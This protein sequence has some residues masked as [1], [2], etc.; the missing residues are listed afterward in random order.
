MGRNERGM[1]GHSANECRVCVHS[2]QQTAGRHTRESHDLACRNTSRTRR[3]RW[4]RTVAS[5]AISSRHLRRHTL[6]LPS[7][8]PSLFSDDLSHPA[9]CRQDSHLRSS[10]LA[11]RL[12]RS[13][14]A[15][16]ASR[17]LGNIL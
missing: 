9:N 7:I 10:A 3:H 13:D 11:V 5:Y 15:S 1:R 2:G 6:P 12:H 16:I 14:Q 8:L 4:L 17:Q